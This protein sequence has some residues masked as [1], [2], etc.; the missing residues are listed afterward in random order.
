MLYELCIFCMSADPLFVNCRIFQE[1]KT[2]LADIRCARVNFNAHDER[3]ND[4]LK[5]INL[6]LIN[7]RSQSSNDGA[8]QDTLSAALILAHNNYTGGAGEINYSTAR[9][10]WLTECTREERERNNAL[11]ITRVI[12]N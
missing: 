11:L 4:A 5:L 2:Q 12:Y 9:R 6:F 7:S 3:S 1:F 10:C 8:V